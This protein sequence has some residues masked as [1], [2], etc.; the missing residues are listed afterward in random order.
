ML[1]AGGPILP[2]S[3]IHRSSVNRASKA[4]LSARAAAGAMASD[5]PQRMIVRNNSKGKVKRLKEGCEVTN[6]IGDPKTK[7]DLA[8]LEM[9]AWLESGEIR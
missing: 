4:D 2:P 6:S 5:R 9:I 3:A 1:L 8:C 7:R